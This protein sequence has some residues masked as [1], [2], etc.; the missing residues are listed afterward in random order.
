MVATKT[1]VVEERLQ[2][3]INYFP[4]VLS[5]SGQS[6]HKVIFGYGDKKELN[7]FLKVRKLETVYPLIWLL[8][9]YSEKHTNTRVE[10]SKAVFILAV[11]TNA[12][13]ENKQR[14]DSNFGKILLPL[15]FTFRKA[16]KN[17]NIINSNNEYD[18]VKHPNYSDGESGEEHPGT[19]I[20]D[21]LRVE[22]D[23]ELMDTCLKELKL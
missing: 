1:I 19:F 6:S 17:A 7:A 13:M 15:F 14:L 2:E 8:Y 20:W 18:V 9:P 10:V 23:F 5:L 11:S 3:I 16:F 22:T 21:A 12:S 4:E